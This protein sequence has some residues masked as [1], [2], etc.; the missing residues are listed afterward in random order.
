MGGFLFPLM[1]LSLRCAL[2]SNGSGP[3]PPQRIDPA[4]VGVFADRHKMGVEMGKRK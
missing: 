3:L 2:A 4:M 1:L